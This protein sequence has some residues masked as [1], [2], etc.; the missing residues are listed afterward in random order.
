MVWQGRVANQGL[1]QAICLGVR[2][3]MHCA[4]TD[5]L[6]ASAP[7]ASWI[8]RGTGGGQVIAA[9]MAP[10]ADASRPTGSAALPMMPNMY[11]VP[12]SFGD[13]DMI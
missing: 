2:V 4:G 9:A 8:G 6:A 12:W 7:P 11:S 5:T 1:P 13:R 3:A 10:D